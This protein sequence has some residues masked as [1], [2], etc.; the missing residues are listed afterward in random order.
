[1]VVVVVVYN[2]FGFW[3]IYLICLFVRVCVRVFV[4]VL[5]SLDVT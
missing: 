5:C 1:M 2:G 4:Y 3:G